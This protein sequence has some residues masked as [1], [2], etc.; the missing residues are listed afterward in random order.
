MGISVSENADRTSL[1]TV[2]RS[3]SKKEIRTKFLNDFKERIDNEDDILYLFYGRPYDFENDSPTVPVPTNSVS[4]DYDIRKGIM[5]LRRIRSDDVVPGIR[6]IEWTQGTVY[7]EY[8]NYEDLENLNYYVF[9]EEQA[10]LYICLDNNNGANS[11]VKPDRDDGTPFETGDGYKWKLIIK[12]D[13]SLIRKFT[14]DTHLPLPKQSGVSS[15]IFISTDGG[16]IDRLELED[17]SPI[18]YD[19]SNADSPSAEIPLFIKG[20]GDD[21]KTAIATGV[22]DGLSGELLSADFTGEGDSAGSGYYVDINRGTV[23]VEFKLADQQ[24]AGAG[25]SPAHGIATINDSGE[26][27]S[28]EVV[29]SGSG[30]PTSGSTKLIIIQ[31][32]A[33]AYMNINSSGIIDSFDIEKAGQNYRNASVIS[34]AGD[35]VSAPADNIIKPIISPFLGHASNIK[36]ELNAMSLFINVKISSGGGIFT[37]NN[38]FRQIGIITNILDNSGTIEKSTFIDAMSS[39]KIQGIGQTTFDNIAIDDIIEGRTSLNIGRLVDILDVEGDPSTKELRFLNDVN[40]PHTKSFEIGETVDISSETGTEGFNVTGV[41]QPNIDIFSGEILF[42][43]NSNA[44]SR[45]AEQSETNNFIF[46]F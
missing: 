45:T 37:Q 30:Y 35:S 2:N 9:V 34:I 6:K 24:F 32:S 4:N 16:Q 46:N 33:I 41:T 40:V 7:N 39:I 12:F 13:A 19:Y 44:I 23:P 28:L 22:V 3:L 31:S 25:F 26:I 15:E 42:I 11:T 29:N 17:E 10:K 27:T 43:N 38:D 36:L 5:S 14:S 21:I 1:A 18:T 8:S 20:D